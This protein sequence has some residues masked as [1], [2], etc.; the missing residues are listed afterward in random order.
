MGKEIEVEEGILSLLL[1]VPQFMEDFDRSDR[2]R[3]GESRLHIKKVVGFK[4]WD[5]RRQKPKR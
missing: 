3:S 5:K 2:C 4:H 1:F